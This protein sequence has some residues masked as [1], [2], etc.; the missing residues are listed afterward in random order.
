MAPSTPLR[1]SGRTPR[2]PVSFVPGDSGDFHAG[3]PTGL[4]TSPD[5]KLRGPPGRTPHPSRRRPAATDADDDDADDD[6][7]DTSSAASSASSTSTPPTASSAGVWMLGCCMMCFAVGSSLSMKRM[8][9]AMPNYIAFLSLLHP[10]VLGL[11]FAAVALW[12]R[13]T[14]AVTDEMT[15]FPKLKFAVMGLWDSLAC[16]LMMFGGVKTPGAVQQLLN[17]ACTPLTMVA[18]VGLLKKRYHLMQWAGSAA[19]MAGVYVVVAPR[20]TKGLNAANAA[21]GA[22]ET[23]TGDQ[24]GLVGQTHWRRFHVDHT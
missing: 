10:I 1:R 23:E 8:T 20:L 19:I 12:R 18:S 7:A 4:L 24:V 6:G 2:K 11:L 15:R 17:Q 14:G 9:T 16:V 21:V 5:A 22:G 13:R 3:V